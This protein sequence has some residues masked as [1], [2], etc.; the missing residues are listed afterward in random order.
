MKN[1]VFKTLAIAALF[2]VSMGLNAQ[3][4]PAKQ[5]T[6]DA[7][8]TTSD[9]V[10][11]GARMP[12]YVT[13]DA[14]IDAL[15]TLGVMKSSHFKWEITDNANA[16]VAISPKKY[17]N[18]GLTAGGAAGYNTENE[19][20]V[21]WAAPAAASATPYKVKA[22][23]HSI[24]GSN[25]F[26]EGCA[27]NTTERLIYVLPVPDAAVASTSATLSCGTIPGAT[28]TYNVPLN[29]TGL[30]PWDVTYTVQYNSNPAGGPATTSVGTAD[31]TVTDANVYTKASAVTNLT[32]ASGLSITLNGGGATNG[33]GMYTIVITNVKDRISKKSLDNI[34][35][36]VS[37]STIKVYVAPTPQTG[38][39]QH[40]AN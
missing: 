11:V 39:V 13:P 5:G 6:Y 29:L 22:T 9:Y 7:S 3:N 26:A 21:V 23:E 4:Y 15:I 33:Y 2:G 25:V 12:Y 30:G 35:G 14:S 28:T 27:G 19:I 37:A 18:S 40:V 38:A 24:P 16:A 1:N 20:S 36:T 8:T 32:G 10:T 34:N 17:D 31:A